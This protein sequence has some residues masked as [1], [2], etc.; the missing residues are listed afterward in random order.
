[1][2]PES[3]WKELAGRLGAEFAIV[4]LGVT[5]ALWADSWV[6]QRRD[7][8]EEVTRLIA[9]QDN[10][11][12]TIDELRQQRDN[13]AGAIRI[14]RRL[15]E[16]AGMPSGEISAHLRYGM[17]YGG[18]FS[19]EL[20]VYDDLKSSGELAM[21]T[22]PD[23]RRALAKMDARLDQLLFAQQDLAVVQQREIDSY[24]VDQMDMRELYG[25]DLGLAWLPPEPDR[26]YAFT[27]QTHFSNR[28]LLKLDLVTQ[29]EIGFSELEQSLLDVQRI[30]A[31]Q[32]DD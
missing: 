8:A 30:I 20:N 28:M 9:L 6:E 18:I 23:L 16:P 26:D 1:M 21:L 5:I 31:R 12:D 25:D 4:V 17:L 14:L 32:L 29:V 11:T 10:V 2:T 15:V 24:L 13:A 3:R 22:N 7:H 27:T 19:A